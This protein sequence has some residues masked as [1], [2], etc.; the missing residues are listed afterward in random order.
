MD[1]LNIARE[2]TAQSIKATSDLTKADTTT[3]KQD[4][5]NIN[6]NVEDVLGYVYT[7]D[8]PS[9]GYYVNQASSNTSGK[10][11]NW[12]VP[13]GVKTIYVTMMG[14]GGGGGG[15]R[16][17]TPSYVGGGG[18]TGMMCYRVPIGVAPQQILSLVTGGGGAG[19]SYSPTSNGI[20]GSNG[21]ASS[22]IRTGTT[23]LS[24][25]GGIGG[26]GAYSTSSPGGASPTR[27][28]R[29]NVSSDMLV[30]L[31]P[32]ANNT[33]FDTNAPVVPGSFFRGLQGYPG[34]QQGWGGSLNEENGKVEVINSKLYLNFL[35]SF[36]I[37]STGLT[38]IGGG[39][40]GKSGAFWGIDGNAG[41]VII[42]WGL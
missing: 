13:T 7:G 1:V 38:N 6:R 40:I 32:G 34:N 24:V 29:N 39:G 25:G 16:T 23:L 14:G 30:N 8:T 21:S 35:L 31:K 2:D 17:D 18:S 12:T 20:S 36:I 5:E 22:I 33:L 27:I 28:V 41:I 9:Y 37:N 4:V 3:I 42:E 15:G 19:G 26:M 10:T 11:A